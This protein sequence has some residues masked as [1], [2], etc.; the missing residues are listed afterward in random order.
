MTEYC[1][2]L[3]LNMKESLVVQPAALE[4]ATIRKKQG[5]ELVSFLG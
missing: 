3:V 5:D 2:E 4:M 1:D